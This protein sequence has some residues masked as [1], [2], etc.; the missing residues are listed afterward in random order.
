ML[1]E[2]FKGTVASIFLL[3]GTSVSLA[4]WW[5]Q[6]ASWW[7]PAG[8]F[9]ALF[10]YGLFRAS[11]EIETKKKALE[12]RIE[13]EEKRAIIGNRLAE[14]RY[15]GV[16]LKAEIVNSDDESPAA[17]RDEKLWEWR[18]SLGDYLE[19]NVSVG[20]A[21]YVDGVTSV[22]A[23]TIGGMK[24]Q[25]TRREKETIVL[26]LNERLNRLTEVMKEY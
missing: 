25:A 16:C 24:S 19:R 12:D 6:Y 10:I 4:A 5:E 14:L 26:H 15:Q 8:L 13:T 3:A 23:A 7:I 1:G 20:K 22:S 9:L 17:V 18:E 21:E 2:G 11:Y